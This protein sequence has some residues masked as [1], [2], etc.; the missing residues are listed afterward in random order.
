MTT[1]TGT[2]TK[3]DEAWAVRIPAGALDG[4][5]RNEV[6]CIEV[7]VVKKS[8]EAKVVE[9]LTISEWS[10]DDCE[11]HHTVAN[12]H[13]SEASIR[14]MVDQMRADGDDVVVRNG[15]VYVL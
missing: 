7:E 9:I 2:W 6:R 4:I 14:R 8:G 3:W 11:I 13:L 5:D 10:N 15:R 12:A 1:I